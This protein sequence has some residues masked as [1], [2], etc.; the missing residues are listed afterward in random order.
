PLVAVAGALVIH[1]RDRL[2]RVPAAVFL[3]VAL[4]AEALSLSRAGW[5]ALLAVAL[6]LAVSVGRR[7]ALALAGAVA[8]GAAG[9]VASGRAPPRPAG[10]RCSWAACS[11]WWPWSCT[12]CSTCRTS[13]TTSAWSCGPWW[14]W[15]PRAP[16][17]RARD[18]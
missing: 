18:Q 2:A 10:G 3:V 8:G 11:P 9:L 7:W 14:R 12:G 13:R 16:G 15:S 1:A 4:P 5:L 6:G 17:G